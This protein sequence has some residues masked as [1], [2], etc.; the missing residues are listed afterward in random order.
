MTSPAFEFEELEPEPIPVSVDGAAGLIDGT[1][2]VRTPCVD[3]CD[4]LVVCIPGRELTARCM[5]HARLAAG[6]DWESSVPRKVDAAGRRDLSGLRTHRRYPYVPPRDPAPENRSEPVPPEFVCEPNGCAHPAP[7]PVS[8]LINVTRELGWDVRWQHS[9]GRVMGGAGKQLAAA[10]IWSVRFRRGAR[11]GYAVRRDD[12]WDS[13]CV[14]AETLPAFMA[15]SVTDLRQWLA[16]PECGVE[17]YDEIR[18]RVAASALAKKLIKCPGPGECE[19][20]DA[21]RGDHTH[22][23]NGDIKIKNSRGEAKSSA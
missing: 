1:S 20:V 12:G 21:G 17:W 16:E 6:V 5:T 9:R 2:F 18:A 11:Q 23:G 3:E 19:W 15:L 13:V 22:R 7:G 8:E 10:E 14:A 4:V